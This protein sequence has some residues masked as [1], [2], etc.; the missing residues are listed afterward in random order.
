MDLLFDGPASFNPT[1]AMNK[2]EL[3]VKINNSNL[4]EWL[5]H[6]AGIQV[7]RETNIGQAT[8]EFFKVTRSKLV[9]VRD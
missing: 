8:C 6:P 2:R 9:E 5:F 3:T 7:I 4:T 1:A